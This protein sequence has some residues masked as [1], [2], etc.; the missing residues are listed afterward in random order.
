MFNFDHK[1]EEAILNIKTK[2]FADGADLNSMLELNK[3]SY[4]KGLTTNPSLMKKAG[5]D[6]YETFAKSVLQNV[7]EKSVSFEVFSDNHDEMYI[8]AKKISSWGDNAFAKIPICNTKKQYSYDLI[9]K[10]SDEN[11]KLNITA[12]MTRDQ[13]DG[14]YNSLNKNTQSFVSI[15]AG[16]IADTGV[17]PEAIIKY[18]VDINKNFNSEIIWASTREVLNIFQCAKLGCDIIT[19]TP[20]LIGKLKNL[21]KNLEEYSVDTVKMFYNDA[22]SAGYKI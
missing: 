7:K 15:F 21:G 11:V 10:L 9:K 19:V 8:Q 18:A 1:T 2:I 22:R 16:R 5:I 20:D 4:I 6:D 13:I 17:E 12:I 14:V 3:L